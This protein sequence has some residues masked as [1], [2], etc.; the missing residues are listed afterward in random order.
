MSPKA[1]VVPVPPSEE[2]PVYNDS[3][4]LTGV[5]DNCGDTGAFAYCVTSKTK[6]LHACRK[7]GCKDA[8]EVKLH[9]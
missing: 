3:S 6:H 2:T 5:C 7:Y 1:K 8:L 9:G 4:H